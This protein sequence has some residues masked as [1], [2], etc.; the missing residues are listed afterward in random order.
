[1]RGAVQLQSSE[2]ELPNQVRLKKRRKSHIQVA[3]QDPISDGKHLNQD[4]ALRRR[5]SRI[6]YR[7]APDIPCGTLRRKKQPWTEAEVEAIM[8][9]IEKYP[10]V[11]GKIPWKLIFEDG[12]DVFH[13]RRSHDLKDKW[14]NLQKAPS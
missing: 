7:E 11:K 13:G 6:E 3:K 10:V 2:K 12:K 4:Y 5:K 9:G 14:R 1:M 8:R